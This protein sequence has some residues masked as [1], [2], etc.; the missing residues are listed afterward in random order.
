MRS[1]W[2]PR[3][4]LA[5][6]ALLPLL[7]GSRTPTNNQGGPQNQPQVNLNQFDPRQA[8]VD[9]ASLLN[10]WRFEQANNL[11][12][13]YFTYTFRGDNTI[14]QTRMV[15]DQVEATVATYAYA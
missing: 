9:R 1:A 10:C 6:L 4:P 11:F 13:S 5:L 3:V 8:A 14:V 15:G 7:G 12:N 2:F